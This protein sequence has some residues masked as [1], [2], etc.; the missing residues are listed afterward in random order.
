MTG[1][2]YDL[3]AAIGYQLT[4]TA[5]QA[6][7]RFETALKT[8]G[9]TRITW[10][11]LLASGE[12]DLHYP[13]DIADFIGIDRTATSRALRQMENS[14]LVSRTAGQ[15]DGRMTEVRLTSSGREKLAAAAPLA[16]EARAETEG[17]L[18][19]EE[20]AELTRLLEKLR[21][22]ESAPLKRL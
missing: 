21:S 20:L 3:H 9:L 15:K 18:T 2:N 4:L 19:K 14:G 1:T 17:R 11:I 5:R 12:A 22:R 13:S 10:C 8:L 6:E 7:R 16:R